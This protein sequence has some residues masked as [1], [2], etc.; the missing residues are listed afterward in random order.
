MKHPKLGLYRHNVNKIRKKYKITPL[1][2]DVVLYLSDHDSASKYSILKEVSNSYGS[3]TVSLNYL[4]EKGFIKQVR[5]HRTGKNGVPGAFA[6]T[7][8]AR[9][10]V[11]EFYMNMF[12]NYIDQEI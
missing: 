6:I 7:G 8:K 1:D 10:M 9:S 3:I 12:P 5:I 11:T 4:R 2:F